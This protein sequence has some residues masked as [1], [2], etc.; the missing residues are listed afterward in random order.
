VDFGVEDFVGGSVLGCD[1]VKWDW[2]VWDE[3][4]GQSLL[5]RKHWPICNTVPNGM[6]ISFE[7]IFGAFA[8]KK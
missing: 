5:I 8:L 7:I 3:G 4:V 2:L 6:G 1:L